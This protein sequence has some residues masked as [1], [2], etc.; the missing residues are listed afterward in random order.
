MFK[1][2]SSS[3]ACYLLGYEISLE[4][5]Q[6][7]KPAVDI[8]TVLFV[9]PAHDPYVY[10]FARLTS[11]YTFTWLSGNKKTKDTKM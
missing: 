11:V 2:N 6:L 4:A 10:A 1:K 3:T 9:L 5:A 7:V 8:N